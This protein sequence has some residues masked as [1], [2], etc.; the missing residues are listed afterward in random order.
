MF[1]ITLNPISFPEIWH[2]DLNPV[3]STEEELHIAVI[4]IQ[5]AAFRVFDQMCLCVEVI[6]DFE[7]RR[8]RFGGRDGIEGAVSKVEHLFHGLAVA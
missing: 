3:Y 6:I 8:F 7:D 5:V 4:V 2:I 1:L